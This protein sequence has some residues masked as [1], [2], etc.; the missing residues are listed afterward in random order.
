MSHTSN[1]V[2][3][4]FRC[5][6]LWICLA[7]LASHSGGAKLSIPKQEVGVNSFLE[8]YQMA[9]FQSGPLANHNE[10]LDILRVFTN[11]RG[12]YAEKVTKENSEI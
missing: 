6:D 5:K 3:T 1:G 10:S 8:L 12:Y 2:K 9:N 7:N 4:S 11:Q